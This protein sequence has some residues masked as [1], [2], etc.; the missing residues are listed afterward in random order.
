MVENPFYFG[1]IV[2]GKA[3]TN[4][5]KETIKFRSC[6]RHKSGT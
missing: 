1:H 5:E 2:A 6:T 3:F 4:R